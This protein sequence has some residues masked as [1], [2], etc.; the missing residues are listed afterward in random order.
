ME[1]N[2]YCVK[3]KTIVHLHTVCNHPYTCQVLLSDTRSH[4]IL[5]L[6]VFFSFSCYGEADM[7]CI[8]YVLFLHKTYL[9]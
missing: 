8:K 3:A 4:I 2:K 7:S 1:R 6:W 5:H 9:D